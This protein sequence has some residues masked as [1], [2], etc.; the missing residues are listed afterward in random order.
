MYVF[1]YDYNILSVMSLFCNNGVTAYH[2]A[3][4]LVGVPDEVHVVA[5]HQE[6]LDVLLLEPEVHLVA[7]H[8]VHME[9]GVSVVGQR[10]LGTEFSSLY[11]SVTCKLST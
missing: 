11:A 7:P 5:G 1:H 6:G 3:T 9:V 2:C 8:A 4:H 10:H